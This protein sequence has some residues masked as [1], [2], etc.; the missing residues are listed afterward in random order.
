MDLFAG[1]L[2]DL[3]TF[4]VYIIILL[5]CFPVHELSHAWTAEYFGDDTPRRSG[6]LSF[7]PLIHIDP[8]GAL[9]LLLRGFGW[10]KP[11]PIDPYQLRRRSP[12]AV[13]WVSLAGPASNLLMAILAAIPF[14]LGLVSLADAF[15]ATFLS[16]PHIFPTLPELL[17][18]FI[19]VNIFLF[20]F[21]LI[22][23]APLDG[24]KI[25]DYFFPPPLSRFMD[26]IRPIGPIL[27]LALVFLGL[28]DPIVSPALS[29]F[30][31]IL[32]G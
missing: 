5:V 21:N 32:I 25:A 13:M 28:L 12:A 24:E 1:I 16:Q 27:L 31:R 8:L 19:Q 29:F 7:N 22:P 26:S 4:I 9:L 20:L 23:L 30:M 17:L 15:A 2:P 3:P 11:V 10:A 14:R 6:R 18:I